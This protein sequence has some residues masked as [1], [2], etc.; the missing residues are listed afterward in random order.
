[1]TDPSKTASPDGVFANTISPTVSPTKILITTHTSTPVP[2]WVKDVS[3]PIWTYMVQ[4]PPDFYD[5]FFQD[6]GKWKFSPAP[7][8]E[9]CND[10]EDA[11]KEISDGT[12]KLSIVSCRVADL[13]HPGF[14]YANYVL[15]MDVNYHN[16]PLGLEF[17]FWNKSPLVEEGDIGLGILPKSWNMFQMSKPN[18]VSVMIPFLMS[19]DILDPSK[20]ATITIFNQNPHFFIYVNSTLMLATD[21]LEPYQGPF[22]MD[23]TVNSWVTTPTEYLML[24]LDNVRIW[25]LDKRE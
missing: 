19:S 14:Q 6:T 18:N 24:E 22:E 16:N 25:D 4:K 8:A 9:D 1:M 15:Q 5:G 7:E 13:T 23:F 20:P 21:R 17:R 3:A 12:M 10:P 2:G 11:V